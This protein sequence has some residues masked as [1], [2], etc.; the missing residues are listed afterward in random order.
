MEYAV[1][2]IKSD[3]G[4][5]TGAIKARLQNCQKEYPW[6]PFKLT[7]CIAIGIWQIF[8][9]QV[10]DDQFHDIVLQLQPIYIPIHSTKR[11]R[12]TINIIISFCFRSTYP[13]S[14]SVDVMHQFGKLIT[15]F[16]WQDLVTDL[17]LPAWLVSF[18]HYSTNILYLYSRQCHCCLQS[19]SFFLVSKLS[20]K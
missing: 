11:I 15:C 17:W 9:Q 20:F 10:F 14:D 1:I 19:Q 4:N 7:G 12:N 8:Y 16:L 3:I 13:I 18:N 5:G 6:S 2:T